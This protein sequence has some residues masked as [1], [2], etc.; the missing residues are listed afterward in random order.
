MEW[1][2]R[3]AERLA[4]RKAGTASDL[5]VMRLQVD[6]KELQLQLQQLAQQRRTARAPEDSGP[7]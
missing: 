2:D 5:D 1:R 4:V 3:S 6:L 7:R